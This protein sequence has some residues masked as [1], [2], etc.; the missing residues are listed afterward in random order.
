[1]IVHLGLGVLVRVSQETKYA[2]RRD[3]YQ[4][5]TCRC[6]IISQQPAHV[7]PFSVQ[8][9]HSKQLAKLEAAGHHNHRDETTSEQQSDAFDREICSIAGDEQSNAK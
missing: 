1:M 4:T 5:N 3:T 7:M 9:T 6:K 2:K 8:Q